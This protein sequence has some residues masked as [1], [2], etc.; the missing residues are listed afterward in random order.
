MPRFAITEKAGR[1]VAGHSN[2]G[3]GSVLQLS[4]EAAKGDVEA[5]L[6]AALDGKPKGKKVLPVGAAGPDKTE[7][8]PATQ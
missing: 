5:G 3:V 6:L 7:G 2:T 8:K 1:I 4:I